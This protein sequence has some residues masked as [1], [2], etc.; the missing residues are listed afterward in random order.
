MND[1]AWQVSDSQ[2]EEA[3][4]GPAEQVLNSLVEKVDTSKDIRMAM[5]PT[6]ATRESSGKSIQWPSTAGFGS[7]Y[8]SN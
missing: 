6:K 2:I 8:T 5:R 7:L 4:D 3:K 1:L